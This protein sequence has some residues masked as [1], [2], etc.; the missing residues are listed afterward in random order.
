M[1]AE[2]G[3]PKETLSLKRGQA[4]IWA[5]NLLHGGEPIADPSSTRRSQV[6]HCYFEGCRYYTPLYSDPALEHYHWREVI[7]ITTGQLVPHV[8]DG[9]EL[10]APGSSGLRKRATAWLRRPAR[11]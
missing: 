1:V 10:E 5:S 8:Y 7:D 3:L 9:K 11:R 4:L 6:T 2:A